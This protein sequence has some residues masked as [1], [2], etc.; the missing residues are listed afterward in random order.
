[1]WADLYILLC[2]NRIGLNSQ[3]EGRGAAHISAP[4]WLVPRA[5][6]PPPASY[7]YATGQNIVG[8]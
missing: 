4:L 2:M 3:Q 1:M 6:Y 5:Y 8:N 7:C